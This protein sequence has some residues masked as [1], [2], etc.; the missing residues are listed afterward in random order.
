MRGLVS[1]RGGW[2]RVSGQWGHWRRLGWVWVRRVVVGLLHW[3][4]LPR[5]TGVMIRSVVDGKEGRKRT[6]ALNAGLGTPG[7]DGAAV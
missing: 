6:M 7:V 3:A 5:K 1:E 2:R 4:S